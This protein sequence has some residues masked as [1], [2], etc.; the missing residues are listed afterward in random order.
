VNRQAPEAFWARLVSHLQSTKLP[1]IQSV[2]P[3]HLMF[4][5]VA[6]FFYCPTFCW[7]LTLS[8]LFGDKISAGRH[9]WWR[10]ADWCIDVQV[11]LITKSEYHDV[12]G[13][14]EEVV[15]RM[16]YFSLHFKSLVKK[17]RCKQSMTLEK[18]PKN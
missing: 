12:I 14:T 15:V 7:L 2:L 11:H 9:C 16:C 17:G 10:H 3:C 8:H 18:E 5:D 13:T 1:Q 6:T 4:P